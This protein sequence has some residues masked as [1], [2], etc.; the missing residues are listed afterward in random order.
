MT[1]NNVF[2]NGILVTHVGG[3][4]DPILG[5]DRPF[6]KPWYKVFII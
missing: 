4:Q 1:I 3:L 2:A 6:E 5:H